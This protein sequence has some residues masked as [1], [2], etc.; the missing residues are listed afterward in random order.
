VE[1]NS[2]KN[3]IFRKYEGL[4]I[5]FKSLNKFKAKE[6]R[7]AHSELEND[8]FLRI[9]LNGMVNLDLQ[10]GKKVK[11]TDETIRVDKLTVYI[12]NVIL[13]DVLK[14]VPEERR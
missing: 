13:H 12:E 3:K 1:K 4:V 2:I 9:F 10:A 8:E 14:I 11:I 7:T 6:L 5:V